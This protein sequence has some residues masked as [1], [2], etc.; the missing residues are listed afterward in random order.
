MMPVGKIIIRASTNSKHTY[1]VMNKN[2]SLHQRHQ[3]MMEVFTPSNAYHCCRPKGEI[4]T[5]CGIGA[6]S[7]ISAIAS[8]LP[9]APNMD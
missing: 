7:P 9:A 6:V 1:G 4:G 5:K 2:R 8:T 3:L